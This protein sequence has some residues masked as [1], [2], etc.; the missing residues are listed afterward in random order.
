MSNEK[1]WF[2]TSDPEHPAN[3][4]EAPMA[5]DDPT[6][7]PEPVVTHSMWQSLHDRMTALEAWAE[8]AQYPWSAKKAA[9][10]ATG[11]A[12]ETYD[13]DPSHDP[14]PVEPPHQ[15]TNIEGQG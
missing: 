2:V 4:E 1:P 12:A 8:S 3:K 9:P 6:P 13:S 7:A 11:V 14:A 10:A 15:D 5:L